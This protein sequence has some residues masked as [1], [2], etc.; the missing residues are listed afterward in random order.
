M[1]TDQIPY[2]LNEEEN[3][4]IPKFPYA[5]STSQIFRCLPQ[6]ISS[7]YHRVPFYHRRGNHSSAAAAVFLLS[8][9]ILMITNE[10]KNL[11]FLWRRLYTLEFPFQFRT[12]EERRLTEL[13]IMP[14]YIIF[15]LSCVTFF[16]TCRHTHTHAFWGLCDDGNNDKPMTRYIL[17][18][19]KDFWPKLYI[20]V[21]T[22]FITSYRS[23][24]V[25]TVS[26]CYNRENLLTK[27]KMVMFLTW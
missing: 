5:P 9:W 6:Q 2:P 26:M 13:N 20:F 21:C 7:T 19:T 15:P 23:I 24:F 22:P 4:I 1:E 11:K 10:R 16:S 18:I 17:R 14:S 8:F 27:C 3:S 12:I 25:L